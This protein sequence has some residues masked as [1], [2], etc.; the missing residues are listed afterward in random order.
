MRVAVADILC[1]VTGTETENMPVV[2]GVYI[3]SEAG[4]D[5]HAGDNN[6]FLG[7]RLWACPDQHHTCK[8]KESNGTYSLQCTVQASCSACKHLK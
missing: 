7:I 3:V 6:P 8:L 4:Y 1:T 5:S 2:E